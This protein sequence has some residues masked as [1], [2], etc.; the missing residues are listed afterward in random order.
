MLRQLICQDYFFAS[1]FTGMREIFL[2]AAVSAVVAA[3]GARMGFR[4]GD[5]V[6][7]A[8]SFAVACGASAYNNRFLYSRITAFDGTTGNLS[9]E[10]VDIK[11]YDREKAVYLLDGTIN[12]SVRAKVT[13]YGT[14]LFPRY[15]DILSIDDGVFAKVQGDY[16]FDSESYYKSQKVFLQVGNAENVTLISKNS[17]T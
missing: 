9:G 6:M 2:L 1:F 12:G 16:L 13:Y 10:V 14:D 17:G 7:L 8:V 5:Y 11:H 3:I 4:R 15:G